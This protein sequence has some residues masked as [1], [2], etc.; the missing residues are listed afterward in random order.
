MQSDRLWRAVALPWIFTWKGDP[1]DR[2][3][4]YVIQS[5]EFGT[6]PLSHAK[7]V[8]HFNVQ[9]PRLTLSACI[10]EA[11]LSKV[12]AR[13]GDQAPITAAAAARDAGHESKVTQST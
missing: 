1:Q 5:K 13:R 4:S 6:S 11:D 8:L 9:R 3:H 7:E 10:S 2:I 12:T